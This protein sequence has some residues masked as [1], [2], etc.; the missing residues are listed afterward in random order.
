VI[1]LALVTPLDGLPLALVG[2]AIYVIVLLVLRAIPPEVF[3]ALRAVRG[4]GP[5]PR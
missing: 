1:A 3:E 5:Q 2:G 4:Y